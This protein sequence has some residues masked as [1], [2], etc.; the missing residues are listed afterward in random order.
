MKFIKKGR[1]WQS[2]NYF[3]KVEHISIR[4][5]FEYRIVLR[6]FVD[7]ECK[8]SINFRFLFVEFLLRMNANESRINC[9]R[10]E[11]MNAQNE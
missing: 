6:I 3:N 2:E 11:M 7:N 5:Q 10:V 8:F 1:S 9:Q 4:K